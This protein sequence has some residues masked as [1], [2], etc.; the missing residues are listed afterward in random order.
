M[1]DKK[2]NK[3][4]SPA[5]FKGNWIYRAELYLWTW[6]F[7]HYQH[8]EVLARNRWWELVRTQG[9]IYIN[10]WS[11]TNRASAEML[12]VLLLLCVRSVAV[13]SMDRKWQARFPSP[14]KRFSVTWC[15]WSQRTQERKGGIGTAVP[16][17]DFAQ[18]RVA[19]SSPQCLAG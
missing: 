15:R 8:S 9:K 3:V 13:K 17:T 2:E 6:H 7:I 19:E 1:A 11:E 4:V 12:S 5:A 10:W 16:E 18:F 14:S